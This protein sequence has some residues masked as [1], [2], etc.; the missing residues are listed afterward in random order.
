M[1]FEYWAN[2]F[3]KVT[4]IQKLEVA[5]EVLTSM[6]STYLAKVSL[7][8]AEISNN[9]NDLMTK[10]SSVATLILPLTFGMP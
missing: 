3:V 5:S 8:V 6:E 7:R 9:M 2:I 1:V 4:L 10:F